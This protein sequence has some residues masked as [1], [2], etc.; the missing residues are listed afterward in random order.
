MFLG[1]HFVGPTIDAEGKIHP[2]AIP[3]STVQIV[4]NTR[5]MMNLGYY[6]KSY[7]LEAFKPLIEADMKRAHLIGDKC[8]LL[9]ETRKDNHP[10]LPALKSW[11]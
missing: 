11:I 10:T 7:K 4:S 1:T 3:T 9:I 6:V 5:M 2:K 8:G